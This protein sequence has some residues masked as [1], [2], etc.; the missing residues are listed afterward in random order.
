LTYYI[1]L[2]EVCLCF[3]F[4]LASLQKSRTDVIGITSDEDSV[5]DNGSVTS[6]VSETKSVIEEGELFHH[7]FPVSPL[8]ATNTANCYEIL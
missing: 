8:F 2:L 5:N 3:G 1:I 4:V 7:Y 6:I